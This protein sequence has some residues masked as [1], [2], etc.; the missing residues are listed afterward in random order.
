MTEQTVLTEENIMSNDTITAITTIVDGLSEFNQE[1]T[2]GALCWT[3]KNQ[4]K[5]TRDKINEV[6]SQLKDLQEHY[7]GSEVQSSLMEKKIDFIEQLESQYDEMHQLFES[8]Q[9]AMQQI[10]GKTWI[11]PA[12]ASQLNKTETAANEAA[13]ALLAKYS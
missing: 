4:M 9:D 8:S 2:I 1:R 5:F 11:E 3:S 10:V 12:K 13:K 7:T 6:V